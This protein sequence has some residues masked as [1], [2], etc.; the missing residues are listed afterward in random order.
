MIPVALS[1]LLLVTPLAGA[2]VLPRAPVR[3]VQGNDDGWAEANIRSFYSALKAAG[4]DTLISAPAVNWSGSGSLDWPADVLNSDGGEFG[5]IPPGGAPIGA[6]AKDSRINYVNSF[7]V[8]AVKYGLSDL[9]P[10]FFGGPPDLVVTGPNV[11]SNIGLTTQ[12]SGTV[13]AANEAVNEGIPAI[14]FSGASGDQRSYTELKA[15]DYSDVYAQLA[16]KITKLITKSKP[17]L[18]TGVGL[19]VNFPPSDGTTCSKASDFKFILTRMNPDLNPFTDDV[20]HCGSVHLPTEST[21]SDAAAGCYVSISGFKAGWKVDISAADQAV[22][23]QKL[24]SLLTCLPT[25]GA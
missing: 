1:C 2:S 7:P 24:G 19:N 5:S 22:V 20:D 23:L 14:A 12:V 11:G 18:P 15:G 8:T 10:K 13:G 3:V 21:V 25:E 17:Y 6:D 16:V 9:A 4:Y